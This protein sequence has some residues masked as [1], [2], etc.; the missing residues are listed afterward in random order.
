MSLSGRIR[1]ECKR[2][3]VLSLVHS[4]KGT[5]RPR[6]VPYCFQLGRFYWFLHVLVPRFLC[7]RDDRRSS[8]TFVRLP[9]GRVF[10]LSFFTKLG[11]I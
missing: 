10:L 1:Q 7:S 5:Q 8:K 2:S 6:F 4:F 3:P 11:P 9:E